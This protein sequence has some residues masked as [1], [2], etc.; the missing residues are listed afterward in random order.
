[1]CSQHRSATH[2]VEKACVLPSTNKQWKNASNLFLLTM[3]STIS[4]E[5]IHP[6]VAR[7]V[8]TKL[9]LGH[10][11]INPSALGWL[12]PTYFP[13]CHPL[14]RWIRKDDEIAD[15]LSFLHIQTL[16]TKLGFAFGSTTWSCAR[17]FLI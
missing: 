6:H 3:G 15:L 8:S 1:M 4:T 14:C 5:C 13:Q 7:Q 9:V 12:N 2:L 17:D 11:M 10:H 16:L